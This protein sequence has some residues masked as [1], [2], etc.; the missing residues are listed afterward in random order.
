MASTLDQIEK[1]NIKVTFVKSNKGQLLLSLNGYLYKC[2]K[3]KGNK[4]YWY[5]TYKDCNKS[6]HTNSNDVYISGGT[7]AHDHEPNPD[8]ISARIVRNKIKER[9]VQ[10][11]L[12]LSLIYEQE[13]SNSSINST[14]TAILPTCQEL[15]IFVKLKYTIL[16]FELF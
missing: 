9:V 8:M 14:T 6:V 7:E 1:E 11:N 15:G 12:P 2:N 5:C 3:G 10:E 4:K 16:F 13:V